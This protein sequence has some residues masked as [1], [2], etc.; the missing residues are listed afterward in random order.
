MTLRIALAL[1]QLLDDAPG[2]I[3]RYAAE[4]A[5][6]LPAHGVEVVAFTARHPRARVTEA[7]RNYDLELEPVI[8]RLPRPA[9]YD[10]WHVAGTAGPQRRVGP[11]DLVHAP[12]LAV[13]PRGDVPLVVTAHDA[14]PLTMPDTFTR[15]GRWFHRKGFEA[16]AARADVV[17]T[18]SDASADEIVGHAGIERARIRVVANGVGLEPASAKQIQRTLHTFGL[19]GR[20]YVFWLGTSQPRKNARVLVDAFARLVRDDAVPHRLVLGGASGWLTDD[21]AAIRALGDRARSLG[22]VPEMHLAALFAGADA[23][24]FPSRHEG[25]GIPVLEAMGQGTPVV[26]GDIPVL[27]EIA[28]GAAR[29]LPPD[30]VEAWAQGLRDLLGDADARAELGARGLAH[31]PRYSWDRCAQETAAVYQELLHRGARGPGAAA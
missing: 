9:L 7:M 2:G 4:L 18:V 12:S 6:H 3:G 13:P 23:F 8:L 14:A 30:D 29:F 5:R 24:A 16:A 19:E 27:R 26:C 20:P 11:V 31:A 22:P 15:R 17:I 10:A 21:E 25:F 28:D 1:E